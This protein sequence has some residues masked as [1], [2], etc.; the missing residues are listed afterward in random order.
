MRVNPRYLEH[1]SP[2][3]ALSVSAA[4]TATFTTHVDA[5]LEWLEV[6]LNNV[7]LTDEE[8]R[9]VAPRIMDVLGQR[10]QG[11]YMA[12]AEEEPKRGEL[13]GSLRRISALNRRVQEVRRL[14]G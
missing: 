11:A 9:D 7:D 12:I 8:I 14:A 4:I 10:L 2:L 1:V 13:A 6:V 3:V 5:R